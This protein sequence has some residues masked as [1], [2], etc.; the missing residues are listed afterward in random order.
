MPHVGG[1]GD[2]VMNW[3]DDEQLWKWIGDGVLLV[4]LFGFVWIVWYVTP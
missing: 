1:K 3:P 2:A 4:C